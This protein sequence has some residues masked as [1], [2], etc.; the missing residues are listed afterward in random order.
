MKLLRVIRFDQTDARV[1]GAAA[2]PDEWAISGAFAF[3]GSD[4]SSLAGKE[5]Q[6]FR[7]GWLGLSSFARATFV[8]VAD[9]DEDIFAQ[10]CETLSQH[11]V[12]FYDPPE[13][14]QA[15]SAATDEMNFTA[16]F[17]KDAPTNTIFTLLRE[18]DEDGALHEE[19]R[20]IE[21]PSDPVHARVWDVVEDDT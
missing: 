1:F 13:F 2:Q 12:E 8:S 20:I 15:M 19:F 21:P 14:E 11:F 6:A 10:C 16:D 3:A 18:F 9:A 17:C 5:R 4:P 7:N